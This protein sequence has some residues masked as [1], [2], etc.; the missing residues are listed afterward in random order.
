M[1]GRG[2]PRPGP[3]RHDAQV[4]ALDPATG[5]GR[6]DGAHLLLRQSPRFPY[7][8]QALISNDGTTI[9]AAV[10]AGAENGYSL[11]PDDISIVSISVATG[12]QVA[13]L[14]HGLAK[15]AVFLSAD[16][17]G[18]FLLLADGSDGQ[19]HGWICRG[20]IHGLPPHNG[21]GQQMAW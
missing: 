17:S 18:Q 11:Q 19:H 7:L 21:D 16:G 8:A 2:S 6:L 3:G 15:E 12:R 13:V 14:Y 5:G 4:W 9:I 20:K 1:D 10:L